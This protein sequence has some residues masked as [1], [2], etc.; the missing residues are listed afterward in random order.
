MARKVVYTCDRCAKEVDEPNEGWMLEF[1]STSTGPTFATITFASHRIHSYG[2]KDPVWLCGDCAA[3]FDAWMNPAPD[4]Q[5][6]KE[7]SSY[8]RPTQGE[9]T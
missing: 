7:E 9:P 8:D 1:E 5:P 3:A 6:G 4:F 2:M